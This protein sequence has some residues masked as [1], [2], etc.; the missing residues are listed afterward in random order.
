MDLFS[1]TAPGNKGQVTLKTGQPT[2]AETFQWTENVYGDLMLLSLIT[3][4]HIR[5]D[6]EDRAITADHPGPLPDRKDGS[7]LIWET[8]S[9]APSWNFECRF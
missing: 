1:V 8:I 4:R 6:P 9:P 3:H 5:I 2:D 7:C